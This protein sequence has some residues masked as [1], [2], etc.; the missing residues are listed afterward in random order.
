MKK[1]LFII[2]KEPVLAAAWL[3][4]VLSSLFVPPSKEYAE[5]I[6]GRTLGIL[7]SLMVIMKGFHHE[8]VFE[9]IGNGL[10]AFTKKV[11]QLV[12]VLVFLCFVFSMVITNDVA[13]I[14]FVPF[15]IMLLHKCERDDLVLIVVVLQTVAANLGSMM[16]PIGNPQN[17]YLYGLSGMSIEHFIKYMFPYAAVSGLLLLVFIFFIKG[18]NRR[19][20]VKEQG[21]THI[22]NKKKTVIYALLFVL[23]LLTVLHVVPYYVLLAGVF[24]VV[25]VIQRQLL[26]EAD[27]HLLLMF[28]GFFIFTGNLSKMDGIQEVLGSLVKNREMFSAIA[29]SQVIS[30]VPAAL[31]LSGF[32]KK[33]KL[34]LLGVNF[35]G[36]G[37]LIASMASLISFKF[38]ACTEQA[39][40]GRYIVVFTVVNLVFLAV[41]CLTFFMQ[42]R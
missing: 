25:L 30:N 7:W 32:T 4:A 2:K 3:L 23:A 14:T 9:C 40:T 20:E 27:Y 16:T 8:Y 15:S 17:L 33:Y 26:W 24:V 1:V 10:I 5:Y 41:L 19:I 37:T 36:L 35:G 11:W 38:Y 34:L 6:D 22:R 13:L 18:K 31:L 28:L 29:C 42:S 21:I 12:L 39:K